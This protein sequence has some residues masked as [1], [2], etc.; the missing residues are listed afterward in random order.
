M[1]LLQTSR[2]GETEIMQRRKRV[3]FLPQTVEAE[4]RGIV[5][6]RGLNRDPRDCDGYDCDLDIY[7]S[8]IDMLIQKQE[9]RYTKQGKEMKKD[10]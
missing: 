1:E 10:A 9:G 7:N 6:L 4:Q 5:C 2:K 3:H 8:C